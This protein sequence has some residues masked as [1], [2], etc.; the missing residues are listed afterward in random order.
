MS[1]SCFRSL[2]ANPARRGSTM[3]ERSLAR[4]R[5]D[6]DA[7]LQLKRQGGTA[8]Q[9]ALA[10]IIEN[11]SAE[12]RGVQ[13]A[14]QEDVSQSMC[15]GGS[16]SSSSSSSA[17]MFFS[18]GGGLFPSAQPSH[19]GGGGSAA[20]GPVPQ[21]THS[22]YEFEDCY[23]ALTPDE[24][25]ELLLQ[26][27]ALLEDEENQHVVAQATAQLEEA[28]TWERDEVAYLAQQAGASDRESSAPSRHGMDE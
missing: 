6:R 1:S 5:S 10:V 14:A 13:G 21:P 16:S 11:S 28:E 22:A 2:K 8:L 17:G 12:A 20:S 25:I 3:I 19:S 7:L 23:D 4:V 18:P 24:R 27:Q 9:A 15:G 26:M